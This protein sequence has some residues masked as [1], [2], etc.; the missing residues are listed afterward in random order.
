MRLGALSYGLYIDVALRKHTMTTIFKVWRSVLSVRFSILVI[1]NITIEYFGQN[2]W[3]NQ[4]FL[5]I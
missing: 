4:C 2:T 3:I 1:V 5:Q